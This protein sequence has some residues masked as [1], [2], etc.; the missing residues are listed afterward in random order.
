MKFKVTI[1]VL[2]FLLG[3]LIVPD[4]WATP[5]AEMT[6][7]EMSSNLPGQEFKSYFEK[8][9]P[10][11]KRIHGEP[12]SSFTF[13]VEGRP[14][15][16]EHG[17]GW[18]P[19]DKQV[20]LTVAPMR[21]YEDLLKVD[22]EAGVNSIEQVVTHELAHAMYTYGNMVVTFP[23]T[24]IN[25]GWA[26]TTELI[27]WMR[28]KGEMP[29]PGMYLAQYMDKDTL[30]GT[31]GLGRYKQRR[32]HSLIYDDLTVG[33]FGLLYGCSDSNSDPDFQVRLDNK[34]YEDY[35]VN[36]KSLFLDRVIPEEDYK[37]LIKT[38]C[39]GRKID[40]QD[41]YEWYF[42]QPASFT[43]GSTGFHLGVSP[44]WWAYT[45]VEGIDVY[46]F[47]RVQN[48]QDQDK[49]EKG[50]SAQVSVEVFDLDG[51]VVFS[52]TTQTDQDGNA[53]L[54]FGRDLLKNGAYYVIAKADYQGKSYQSKIFFMNIRDKDGTAEEQRRAQDAN[55]VIG[56]MVDKN[57]T[58]LSSRYLAVLK[59]LGDV[60]ITANSN[61]VMLAE[62]P[63]SETKEVAFDFQG[64]SFTF[65]KPP[66]W[67]LV[68][69][70]VSDDLIKKAQATEEF[71]NY[72]DQ[73]PAE[74]M[75]VNQQVREPLENRNEKSSGLD[76]KKLM[77]AFLSV[78]V[79]AGLALGTYFAL[80]NKK[81]LK[82]VIG[83]LEIKSQQD[84]EKAGKDGDK[85]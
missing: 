65:T 53:F 33:A 77:I 6:F 27:T 17:G 43:K 69:F 1:L 76:V 21:S 35:I 11:M 30:A 16:E 49:T 72:T 50:L 82:E 24:W 9:F 42:S 38:L 7:G 48:T 55:E 51:K 26:K 32:N 20:V 59:P 5:S 44:H 83:N 14:E 75:S 80:A 34:I 29:R 71:Q 2:I 13:T 84:L 41:A 8:A 15:I 73:P 18:F 81:R 23:Y 39:A 46:T 54:N 19:A 85:K 70:K 31:S 63:S 68:V 56:V 22:P 28:I 57:L 40:G 47:D 12:F 4:V 3:F 62:V 64:Q 45:T 10:E 79:M 36:K 61:G 74:N 66:F 25:E 58:P 52:K 67:R 78:T 60:K 37:N